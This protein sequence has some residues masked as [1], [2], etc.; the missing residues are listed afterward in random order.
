M[1]TNLPA[2]ATQAQR[3]GKPAWRPML[4]YVARLHAKSIRPARPP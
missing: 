3:I 4:E 1:T 2:L